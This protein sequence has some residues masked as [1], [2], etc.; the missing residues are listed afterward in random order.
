VSA[1]G[2][3]GAAAS[4]SRTPK[5]RSRSAV[6]SIDLASRR[7][8]HIGIAVLHSIDGA[9]AV[10]L[11]E[12]RAHGMIGA[13][14]VAS[15]ARLA[16]ELASAA[17]ARLILIDGPQG[18]R[19]SA[20]AI[21]HMRLCE[22]C[23]ATPGK[24]GLPGVVKPASWTA[25]ARF[26]VGLFDELDGRG[27]PRLAGESSAERAAVEVFPTRAW[28]ALGHRPLPAKSRRPDLAPWAE[29]L[30]CDYGIAWPRPPSHDELQ[31]VVAGLGGL[32]LESAELAAI[33]LHGMP[34]FREGGSWREGFI[35]SP[36]RGPSAATHAERSHALAF[37]RG[38]FC[39]S[40]GYLDASPHAML[41]PR[42]PR[43]TP[44]RPEVRARAGAPR[45]VSS[46]SSIAR[47]P[48]PI[49]PSTAC[50]R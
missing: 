17:G 25:M 39:E 48:G 4:P 9:T 32:A 45:A 34:P 49:S 47:A 1:G 31:A 42:W 50:R 12:P 19:A 3:G 41:A 27:W 11:V 15:V 2:A 44:R 43:T 5:A 14:Q 16:V 8:D 22:R 28:R 36:R 21:D 30:A 33:D 26:S 35:L 23:T 37:V 24:T 7:F 6:V 13:P 40:R 10:E 20:S 29:R 38:C 18:W 46:S